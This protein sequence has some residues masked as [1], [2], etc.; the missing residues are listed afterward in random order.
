MN[1]TAPLL[2]LVFALLPHPAA[3]QTAFFND[4]TDVIL[5]DGQTVIAAA[6]TYEAVLLFPNA[7][8]AGGRVFNEWTGFSEDKLLA[9]GP[10]YAQGYNFPHAD[11][12]SGSPNMAPDV[13]HHVAFVFDGA[14]ERLYV[15]GHLVAS[16]STSGGVGNGGGQAHIGAIFRDNVL[17]DGFI[18]Y[19]ES[20]RI[21][22]VA[23]Y[24]GSMFDHPVGDLASD[25]NTLLLFNFDEPAGSTTVADE[26]PLGR[27]GALGTGFDGATAPELGTA[28]PLSACPLSD[29]TWD[30]WDVSRGSLLT[31][32][33]GFGSGD[34]EEGE[35]IFGGAFP[36]PEPG[37]AFFQDTQPDGF[38]HYVEWETTGAI[39]P[40]SYYLRASH[41]QGILRRVFRT[42]RLFGYDDNTASFELLYEYD[43]PLPYGGG[44]DDNLLS[45]CF[46]VP[47]LTTS[48]YRAEFVQEGQG[49]FYGPRVIELDA[50]TT[51]VADLGTTPNEGAPST[52]LSVLGAPSPNPSRG[53]ARIAFHL[54]R[55]GPA[56]LSVYDL[57][58][59]ELAVLVEGVRASGPH[60]AVF[61][62]RGLP[63]GVYLVRLLA[64]DGPPQTRTLTLLR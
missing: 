32:A 7:S 2:A 38:A 25:A 60:D 4:T 16:Q 61:E 58:G 5:V 29:V 15:D 30:L 8:G 11:I 47:A 56:R 44:P 42:F 13:W 1:R 12:L 27:T 55:P 34:D 20:L 39:A 50:F 59:R 37:A 49:T 19:L 41:D 31:A 10:T 46:D 45:V 28:P 53:A 23:R 22:D 36:S 17:R 54:T 43:P 51:P 63:S 24:T 62:G 6:S 48:R 9:A 26:S 3:A 52:P 33:S 35:N 40:R 18:G 57:L 64:G 14:E 21:S